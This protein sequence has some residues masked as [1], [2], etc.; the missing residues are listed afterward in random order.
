M[1]GR[2]FVLGTLWDCSKR[3]S[4]FT[5]RLNLTFCI[6]TQI[7]YISDDQQNITVFQSF[8]SSFFWSRSGVPMIADF[9]FFVAFSCFEFT[10]I[11]V[12]KQDNN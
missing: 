11:Q 3:K 2:L 5:L 9:S 12:F 8:A 1:R 4:N 10:I 7:T 6:L